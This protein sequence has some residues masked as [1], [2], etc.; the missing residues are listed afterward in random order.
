[1][2][3]GGKDFGMLEEQQEVQ[4]DNSIGGRLRL[5]RDEMKG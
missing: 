1:M 2:G 3:K 5:A 4:Y